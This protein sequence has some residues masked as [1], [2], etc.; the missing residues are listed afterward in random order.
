LA[1]FNQNP[2]KAL[3]RLRTRVAAGGIRGWYRQVFLG[4]IRMPLQR[5][6]IAVTFVAA[7]TASADALA[8]TPSPQAPTVCVAAAVDALFGSSLLD[9]LAAP[10]MAEVIPAVADG[11]T[12]DATVTVEDPRQLLAQVAMTLRDIRYRRGGNVPSTGFDCSGFVHY[13]FAQAL[14]IDLPSDSASQFQSGIKI[15][16]G[17][18]KTGDLVFFRIHGKRISHVGIY[19]DH[20]RF[21]HSPTSGERVRVDEL[22]ASYWA[23]RFAGAKRPDSLT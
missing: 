9:E 8:A 5:L 18:M 14:G 20:G 7:V 16:R 1:G 4:F 21:I 12:Q 3:L 15:A 19:L 13:V 17:E 23:K 6:I 10:A 22:G 2:T 11:A